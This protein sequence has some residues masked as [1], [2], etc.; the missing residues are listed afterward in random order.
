MNLYKQP[1]FQIFTLEGVKH[2][3]PA[4]AYKLLKNNELFFVD[5]REEIECN[6][7]FIDSD[8]ILY[9]PMSAIMDRLSSIPK[10][11][12]L[13]VICNEGIRSVKVANLLNL[14]GFE[15]VANV[16]GGLIA[17]INQSLPLVKIESS[18]TNYFDDDPC[19]PSKCAGGCSGCH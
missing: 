9:H 7:E 12:P 1:V 8:N 3:D 17:W 2:I 16:D 4:E 19:N 11:I 10:N 15:Q 14:Q 5:V 18:E 6:Y 13:A